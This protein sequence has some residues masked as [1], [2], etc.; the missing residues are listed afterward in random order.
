MTRE[1]SGL[2]RERCVCLYFRQLSGFRACTSEYRWP[3]LLLLLGTMHFARAGVTRRCIA[4]GALLQ[5]TSRAECVPVDEYVLHLS[6]P[7]SVP[8]SVPIS[9]AVSVPILDTG[10]WPMIERSA[11]GPSRHPPG[12]GE[13]R[14]RV[15]DGLVTCSAYFE[16]CDNSYVSKRSIQCR[17]SARRCCLLSVFLFR[18]CSVL[19]ISACSS[20]FSV[21]THAC[22]SYYAF[23]QEARKH[24]FLHSRWPGFGLVYLWLAFTSSFRYSA[25]ENVR[26]CDARV[27]KLSR[28]V[29]DRVGARIE[30]PSPTVMRSPLWSL[31]TRGRPMVLTARVP[32][33]AMA[34]A[35]TR[36]MIILRPTPRSRTLRIPLSCSRLPACPAMATPVPAAR[37]TRRTTTDSA[38]PHP[39]PH[40]L[41]VISEWALPREP[42]LLAAGRSVSMTA[43]VT[44][45]N[46]PRVLGLGPWLCHLVGHP[47]GRRRC[48]PSP[49]AAH[50]PA[51]GAVRASRVRQ[52]LRL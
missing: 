4:G 6:V 24:F 14:A 25:T 41:T 3:L 51:H 11:T 42:T 7:V 9:V 19:L 27:A 49:G 43:P 16:R 38:A 32:S 21:R 45:T 29:R 22:G 36:T 2:G 30:M 5:K 20:L 33:R 13:V 34:P 35:L 18:V 47:V 8:I 15:Q 26:V 40:S 23:L 44:A 37:V 31:S 48:H 50:R 28:H 10:A 39:R 46:V 12:D 17:T 52:A 1:H